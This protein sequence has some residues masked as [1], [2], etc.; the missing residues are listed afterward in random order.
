M[1]TESCI[2]MCRSMAKAYS[3]GVWGRSPLCWIFP[4]KAIFR[5]YFAKLREK[6]LWS[7]AAAPDSR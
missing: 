5:R 3:T 4:P 1:D 6:R 2:A 7:T